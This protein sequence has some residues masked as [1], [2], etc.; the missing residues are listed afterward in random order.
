M[1]IFVSGSHGL[2]G[3]AL[4]RALQARGDQVTAIRRSGETLDLSGIGGADAVVHLAGAPLGERRWDEARK[5]VIM[6]S[7]ETPTRQ[8]AEAL[9]ALDPG[10]RPG[11]LISG[12]AVG[13]YGDR[14]DQPLTEAS[15]GGAG[16]LS[17]VCRRWEGATAVA[18]EAGIRVVRLRTGV[19][20]SGAG[21]ALKPLLLPFKL[22][23]GGRIGTGR[24][25]F[26]WIALEDEIN[27]IIRILDTADLRGPVNATAPNPVTY[28]E[29]ARTLAASCTGPR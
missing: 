12:S 6:D 2:I 11:V 13:F 20:L 25:W 23:L 4:T 10:H 28:A 3:S 27:A 5:R 1:H 14:G 17:E 9:A 21:G 18:D 19:V 24:Q 15:E 8:L 29:F 26:S 22:G 16:F 7:R